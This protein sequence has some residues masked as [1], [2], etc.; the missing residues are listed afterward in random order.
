[1]MDRIL[2]NKTLLYTIVGV[3]LLI[4]I[5]IS[6]TYAFFSA[7]ATNNK[8]INGNTL[9]INLSLDVKKISKVGDN[10]S[11]LIPIHDGTVS[12]YDSQLNSAATASNQ[13]VDKN[14][15]TV[16]QV[17]EITIG[18]SGSDDTS[19]NTSISFYKGNVNNL[20]WANMSSSN[21]VGDTHDIVNNV[22]ATVLSNVIVPG[23]S[24]N[25]KQYVMIYVSNTGNDQSE[26]DKDLFS[27]IVTV[28]SIFG[29]KITAKF[30]S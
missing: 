5:V 20:K 1:M 4:V 17:Y 7:S 13:C 8:D 16:C 21:S 26:Q 14:G 15:N 11:K 25:T 22:S 9:D 24:N 30:N 2:K 12:G 28:T 18:N 29:D 10:S 27:G 19:V 3:V 23:N 6:G